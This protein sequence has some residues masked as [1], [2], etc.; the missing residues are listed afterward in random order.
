MSTPKTM[1]T[2]KSMFETQ[3][4]MK[5]KLNSSSK[6]SQQQKNLIKKWIK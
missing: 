2:S 1:S 4:T 5:L 6:Y 3:E